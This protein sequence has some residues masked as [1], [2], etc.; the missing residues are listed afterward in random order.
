MIPP[1]PEASR[2]MMATRRWQLLVV[3]PA[4]LSLPVP[5]SLCCTLPLLSLP[6]LVLLLLPSLP[7]PFDCHAAAPR[8]YRTAAATAV[9]AIPGPTW[10][11]QGGPGHP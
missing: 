2:C 8:R 3:L 5:L 6:P 4:L 11:P 1:L 7:L 10:L 9:T